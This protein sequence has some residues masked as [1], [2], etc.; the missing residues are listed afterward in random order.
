MEENLKNVLVVDMLE[1]AMTMTYTETVREDEG[2]A[3][4]VPVSCGLQEYPETIALA[5]IQLPTAPEK[6]EHMTEIVYKGIDDICTNGTK[7]DYIQKAKE[8]LL[9][10]HE[11]K[12]KTNGYWLNQIVNLTR[13]NHNFVDGYE[14]TVNSIT[15]DDIKAM[16]NK[17]FKSGNKLVIGITSPLSK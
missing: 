7:E 16:A 6:R 4:G 3:Y 2:G 5:Q 17:I 13:Y 8:Y 9:R 10:S 12:L 14:D 1:Q 15:N 11:E